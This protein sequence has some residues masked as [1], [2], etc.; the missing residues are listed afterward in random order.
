MKVIRFAE[1]PIKTNPHGVD[2]RS[3]YDRDNAQ[4][5]VVSLQPGQTLK[6]HITHTEVVFYVL[7]GSPSI[8]VGEI[9]KQVEKDA[10]VESPSGIIHCI[11]NNDETVARVL[12]I[13]APRP[14]ETARLL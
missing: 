7:E 6:P 14:L 8:R 11:S 9:T 2:V 3:M 5:N 12:V 10:L 13:K 1:R 4:V